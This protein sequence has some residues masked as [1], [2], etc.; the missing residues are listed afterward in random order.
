VNAK[1]YDSADLFTVK[2]R[3]R[4]YRREMGSRTKVMLDNRKESE[5]SG[6]VV[7]T[8]IAM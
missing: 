2:R 6:Q 3:L 1:V 5:K 4:D 7:A 8:A